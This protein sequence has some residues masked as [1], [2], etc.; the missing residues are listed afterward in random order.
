MN[1]SDV[2]VGVVVVVVVSLHGS[3]DVVSLWSAERCCVDTVTVSSETSPPVH[4]QH[5]GHGHTPASVTGAVKLLCKY[6]LGHMGHMG[7][8]PLFLIK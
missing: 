8:I 3:G 2:V 7:S 4:H 6:T 1:L 5:H